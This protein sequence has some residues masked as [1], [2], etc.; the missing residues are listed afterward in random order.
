VDFCRARR[1][2][3]RHMLFPNRRQPPARF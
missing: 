2:K 1:R 3:P